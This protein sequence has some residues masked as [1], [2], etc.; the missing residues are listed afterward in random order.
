MKHKKVFSYGKATTSNKHKNK[1]VANKNIG[2]KNYEDK[3]NIEK[4]LIE[5]KRQNILLLEEIN[6]LKNNKEK[7]I[8]ETNKF[9]NLNQEND[10]LK[11]DNEK[12][13]KNNKILKQ[14]IIKMHEENKNIEI[15]IT[16]ITTEYN[17]HKLECQP[18]I[19]NLKKENNKLQNF[20][21]FCKKPLHN[22]DFE[23]ISS[24]SDEEEIIKDKYLRIRNETITSVLNKET[25]KSP[26]EI[27]KN[28]SANLFEHIPIPSFYL[29]SPLVD[30]SPETMEKLLSN[31]N[32]KVFSNQE[33]CQ[34]FLLQSEPSTSK[35]N[36]NSL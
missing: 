8:E 20:I 17:N 5:E 4:L 23:N 33:E 30:F 19:Q 32:F 1:K 13:E 21:K 2:K 15:K 26:E 12:L 11:K 10:K 22:K 9:K 24:S 28:K 31:K 18:K 14:K 7:E 3:D 29:N 36:P 16:N 35:Y 34:E 25:Q 27:S 6:S